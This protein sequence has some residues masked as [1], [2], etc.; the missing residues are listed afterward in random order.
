VRPIDGPIDIERVDILGDSAITLL[1]PEEVSAQGGV[2]CAG[3]VDRFCVVIVDVQADSLR[4]AQ[5]TLLIEATGLDDVSYLR[6]IPINAEV[7]PE[8]LNPDTEFRTVSLV[9][10][11]AQR[12]TTVRQLLLDEMSAVRPV[13]YL[14][15]DRPAFGSYTSAG[16]SQW[17]STWFN[18]VFDFSGIAWDVNQAGTALTRCHVTLA[19][20]YPRG[21]SII[22]HRKNGTRFASSTVEQRLLSSYG[23]ARDVAIYRISPCLP[24][25]MKV[26][27]LLDGTENLTSALVGAPLINTHF[28]QGGARAISARVIGGVSTILSGGATTLFPLVVQANA[29]SGDSGHPSFVFL[30]GELILVSQFWTGGFGSGPYLGAGDLQT[31][32]RQ[33]IADMPPS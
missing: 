7:L 2:P 22:F 30:D 20:H 14:A 19:Q 13:S 28:P 26:Y 25:D 6:T 5:S 17:A 11:A 16:S 12:G 4:T 24:P 33:A 15:S 9:A 32:L 1:D 29:V 3:V 8:Q 31:A 23:I 18:S 10:I 27:P 21:G